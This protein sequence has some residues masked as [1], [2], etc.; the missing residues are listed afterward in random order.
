MRTDLLISRCRSSRSR[1][2]ADASAIGLGAQSNRDRP[3]SGSSGQCFPERVARLSG[4]SDRPA[5]TKGLSR[6]LIRPLLAVKEPS[7]TLR[8]YLRVA[9]FLLILVF[10]KSSSAWRWFGCFCRKASKYSRARTP[11]PALQSAVPINSKASSSSERP[12]SNGSNSSSVSTAS[13]L[14]PSQ[15]A[16]DASLNAA[17]ISD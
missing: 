13:S 17:F 8:S 6:I 11:S 4:R 14:R 1:Q 10:S 16:S 7:H 15:I 5:D 2:G 12:C 3:R 9:A